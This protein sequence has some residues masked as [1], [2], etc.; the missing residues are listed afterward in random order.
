[1]HGDFSGWN[2]ARHGR[3]RLALWDWEWAR[4]GLPLEDYFHWTTQRLV[5]F[6]RGSVEQLVASALDP[7]AD[8]RALCLELGIGPEQAPVALA[9]SLRAG[10][11]TANARGIQ[12]DP[13]ADALELLEEAP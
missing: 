12:D 1:V 3:E 4:Y 9:A 11:E 7:P 6:G 5:H 2:S 10:I 8:L 13:R